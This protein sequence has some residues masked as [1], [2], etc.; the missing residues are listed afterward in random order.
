MARDTLYDL[1]REIAESDPYIYTEGGY[2]PCKVKWCFHCDA[3]FRDNE[4]YEAHIPW[5]KADEIS[6]DRHADGCL[7]VWAR[8][9]MKAQHHDEVVTIA[10]KVYEE[11]KEAWEALANDWKTL[12]K[13]FDMVLGYDGERTGDESDE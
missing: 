1:A 11:Y 8:E 6:N 3:D 9:R 10:K 12:A 2:E 5:N 13:D 4:D 7:W